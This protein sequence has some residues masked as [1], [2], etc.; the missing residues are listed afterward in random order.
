MLTHLTDVSLKTR[1]PHSGWP[2]TRAGQFLCIFW[3]TQSNPWIARLSPRVVSL[4]PRGMSYAVRE[5][6]ARVMGPSHIRHLLASAAIPRPAGCRLAAPC[7][8]KMPTLPT[9]ACRSRAC[10]RRESWAHRVR[11]AAL[12]TCPWG[13]GRAEAPHASCDGGTGAVSTGN[14]RNGRKKALLL[15]PSCPRASGGQAFLFLPSGPTGVILFLFLPSTYQSSASRPLFSPSLF[16]LTRHIPP[17][18][19]R[20]PRA[21]THLARHPSISSSSCVVHLVSLFDLSRIHQSCLPNVPRRRLFALPNVV[22][23]S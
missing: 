8:E 18:D 21:T 2:P 15:R 7:M 5:L 9:A 13:P 11:G 4:T 20:L 14:S 1:R 6:R 16:N 22:H 23:H 12:R 10:K 3:L 17:R 19:R